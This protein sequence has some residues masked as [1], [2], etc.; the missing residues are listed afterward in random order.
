MTD[1]ERSYEKVT[2]EQRPE[3]SEVGTR[4]VPGGSTSVGRRSHL[5][6]FRSQGQQEP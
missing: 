6:A 2:S 1:Q 3:G 4:Q 5:V